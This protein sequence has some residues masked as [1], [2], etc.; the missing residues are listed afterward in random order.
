MGSKEVSSLAG[1]S[2][3]DTE[4]TVWCKLCIVFTTSRH[5]EWWIMTWM[6]HGRKQLC[7]VLGFCA[8]AIEVSVPLGCDAVWQRDGCITFW[9]SIMVS[10]A[11]VK[12]SSEKRILHGMFKP[13]KIRQLHLRTVMLQS[14]SGTVPLSRRT[15][16]SKQMWSDLSFILALAKSDWGM[17]QRTSVTMAGFLTAIETWYLLWCLL[18][19]T[20]VTAWVSFLIALMCRVTGNSGEVF[21]APHLECPC[22]GSGS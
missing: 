18:N 6:V 1:H 19:V 3:D 9:D 13:L 22:N 17:L 5:H 12:L 2:A 21:N 14:H 8:T 15:E 11:M 7:K 10:S 16:T 20:S 4:A